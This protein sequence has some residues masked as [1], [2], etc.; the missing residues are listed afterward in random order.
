MIKTILKFK[1]T[2]GCD[3][4]EQHI[5]INNEYDIVNSIVDGFPICPECGEDMEYIG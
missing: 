5:E 3:Y 1:N 4:E 2:C